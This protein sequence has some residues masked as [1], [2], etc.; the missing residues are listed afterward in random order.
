MN[1]KEVIISFW[2][3][4]QTNDFAM[5]SQWLSD[6]FECYWPQSSEKLIG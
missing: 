4:M 1:S 6:D 5:A 2:K 3:A